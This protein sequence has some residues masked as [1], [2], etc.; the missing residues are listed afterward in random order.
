MGTIWHTKFGSILFQ[1]HN[2]IS[3]FVGF[4]Q[5]RHEFSKML[6]EINLV[7]TLSYQFEPLY[8][9]TPN[10]SDDSVTNPFSIRGDLRSF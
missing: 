3:L 7:Q 4:L 5:T 1:V 8:M 2:R 10:M 9:G 6:P